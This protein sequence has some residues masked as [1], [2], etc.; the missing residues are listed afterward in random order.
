MF[1]MS[2]YADNVTILPFSL[3]LV[4]ERPPIGQK[5]MSLGSNS[6]PFYV[7]MKKQQLT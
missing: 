4:L 5:P 3:I 2:K 7:S 1:W 6:L